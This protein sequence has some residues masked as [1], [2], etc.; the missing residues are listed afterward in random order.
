MRQLDVVA[1]THRGR[2]RDYNQ[3]TVSVAGFQS[4]VLEGQPVR[5]AVDPVR[6]VICLVADGLGG[7]AEGSRASRLAAATIAD[8]APSL[9][10]G[11]AVADAVRAANDAVYA[12]MAVRPAWSGMGTTI[13][14]LVVA[15]ERIICANVGD[16]RCF[17]LRDAHLVQLS[18]DDS[19][20]PPPGE[21]TVATVVTQSLGGRS[22]PTPVAPHL[23]E[24]DVSPGDRFLLCSDGLTDELEP[25]RI[26]AELVKADDPVAAVTALL[27]ATLEAGARDN[28]SIVLVT[29]PTEP[30]AEQAGTAQEGTVP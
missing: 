22:E 15:G 7:L 9:H 6:P 29:V 28:V 4:G 8:A 19:V 25:E 18:R 10:D 5:F 12:E 14:L 11:R 20:V 1:V 30:P 23:I 24:V 3:D 16:S 27:G 26:E 21:A 13:V 17:L 2:A